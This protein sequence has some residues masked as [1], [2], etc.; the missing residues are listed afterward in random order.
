MRGTIKFY[1]SY[2]EAALLLQDPVERCKYYDALLGYAFDGV[3]PDLGGTAGAMFVLSKPNIDAYLKRS[4]AGKQGGSKP[5]ANAK[6]T[7]SKT[8]A[9]DKQN[10]SKSKANRKQ[11][12]TEEEVEEEEEVEVEDRVINKRFTPP[13]AE[14]VQAYC[15]ERN[16]GVDGQHFVDY[17]EARG[18]KVGGKQPMKDWKAAVRT[19]ERSGYNKPQQ[20]NT[21]TG[22]FQYGESELAAI[23]ALKRGR[24]N[25]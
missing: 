2:W 21:S 12:P 19:W 9:K 7:E 10:A 8:E 18:W 20:A 5:K 11:T 1:R 14:E 17:Y 4:D 24:T 3:E 16:N 13:K 23:R 22:V 15:D 25:T 6:Q